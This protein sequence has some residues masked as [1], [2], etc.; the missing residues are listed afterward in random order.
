MA[1]QFVPRNLFLGKIAATKTTLYTVPTGKTTM[2][3]SILL[4]NT[5]SSSRAVNM[6]LTIGGVS[7]RI[8]AKDWELVPKPTYEIDNV[9]TITEGAKIEAECTAADVVS[10]VISGVE[11]A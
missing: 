7:E 2:V 5:D 8:C 4:T 10:C 11:S 9:L 3:R 6:Y 1:Q